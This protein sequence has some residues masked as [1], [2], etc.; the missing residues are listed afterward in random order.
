MT[1]SKNSLA[2]VITYFITLNLVSL[3]SY[4]WG[5]SH[6]IYLYLTLL[7]LIGMGLMLV[8]NHH[9]SFQNHF[10]KKKATWQL[11]LVWVV[12]GFIGLLLSQAI[13][14]FIESFF[15]HQTLNSTNTQTLL[16]IAKSYP[17][18]S[19]VIVLAA[20]VM[21]ELVFRKVL[22]G[23]VSDAFASKYALILSTLLFV[24]AHN[25][26]HFLVYALMGLILSGVYFKTGR[27]EASIA[28]HL[29]LNLFIIFNS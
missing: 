29:A 28:C 8:F 26:G 1:N 2:L 7:N 4:F 3:S 20:P 21:E 5:H 6:N 22:F 13:A 18:Y 15:F 14:L 10:E 16:T 12:V 27:I 19:L 11:S 23:N 24:L 17:Y 25:D 9:F